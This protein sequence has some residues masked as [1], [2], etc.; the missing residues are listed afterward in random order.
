MHST[1]III[2]VDQASA[3]SLSTWWQ[4]QKEVEPY[5]FVVQF[6]VF[7]FYIYAGAKEG[8]EI[9][10]MAQILLMLPLTSRLS[11]YLTPCTVVIS[12]TNPRDMSLQFF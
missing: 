6:R 12:A 7:S 5:I 8:F 1:V 3:T 4:Q 10:F 11:N 9:V 2:L